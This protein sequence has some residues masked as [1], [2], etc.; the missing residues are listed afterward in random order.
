MYSMKFLLFSS[1]SQSFYLHYISW[2]ISKLKLG[3]VSGDIN[4]ADEQ[5]QGDSLFQGFLVNL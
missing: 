4:W 3:W 1:S 5:L 2:S